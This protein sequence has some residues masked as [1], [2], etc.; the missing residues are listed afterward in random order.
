MGIK[1]RTLFYR[2]DFSVWDMVL[3]KGGTTRMVF[4]EWRNNKEEKKKNLTLEGNYSARVGTKLLSLIVY[5]A[6]GCNYS[7][8]I[9]PVS[10]TV[11]VCNG[12]EWTREY[13]TPVLRW[14]QQLLHWNLPISVSSMAFGHMGSRKLS[15]RSCFVF[16]AWK[17]IL[18]NLYLCCSIEWIKLFGYTRLIFAI[19]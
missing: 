14:L 11:R 10:L 2:A 3:E 6:F 5:R 8:S 17:K 1:E 12:T 19:T 15:S 16:C 13:K 18:S 9:V 7:L 4:L